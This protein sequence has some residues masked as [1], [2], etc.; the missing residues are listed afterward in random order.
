MYVE[1]LGNNVCAIHTDKGTY[2]QSY[3]SIVALKGHGTIT[4]YP[5]WDFSR[6]TMKHVTQFL[7]Y[8][9]KELRKF[10]QTGEHGI[11]YSETEPSL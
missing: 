10:I 3:R 5:K 7:G 6:T 4:L 1:Q 11:Q 9:S 2:L 8:C